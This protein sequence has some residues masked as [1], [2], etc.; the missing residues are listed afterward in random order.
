M[1]ST[2]STRRT[3]PSPRDGETKTGR[4]NQNGTALNLSD[5]VRPVPFGFSWVSSRVARCKS[6]NSYLPAHATVCFNALRNGVRLEAGPVAPDAV[7]QLGL[8]THFGI[9]IGL[10]LCDGTA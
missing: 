2:F 6:A 8:L 5:K 7:A 1:T 4:G 9:R 10:K 3:P